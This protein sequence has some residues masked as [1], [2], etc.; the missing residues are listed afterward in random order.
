[1]K[2]RM[3]DVCYDYILATYTEPYN[4]K[5]DDEGIVTYLRHDE[6]H[7]YL[8]VDYMID[9][10]LNKL[11]KLQL[12]VIENKSDDGSREYILTLN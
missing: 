11:Y 9:H 3:V 10:N 5:E 6:G 8:I 2:K 4:F 1:M 12:S 7:A